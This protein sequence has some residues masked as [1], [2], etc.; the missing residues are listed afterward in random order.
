MVAH[1]R[2]VREQALPQGR[3]VL[4]LQDALHQGDEHMWQLVR[5]GRRRSVVRVLVHVAAPVCSPTETARAK[6]TRGTVARR[7]PPSASVHRIAS[8]RS[9]SMTAAGSSEARLR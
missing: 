9:S 2:L 4:A 1:A 3:G 5:Y 8:R 6:I 7:R